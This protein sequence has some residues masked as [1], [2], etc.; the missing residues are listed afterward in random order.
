MYTAGFL[1]GMEVW[2]P[3]KVNSQNRH[4]HRSSDEE[5]S[6][7]IVHNALSKH[8]CRMHRPSTDY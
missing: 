8:D 5:L 4:C 3:G 7:E 1:G 6:S 2:A